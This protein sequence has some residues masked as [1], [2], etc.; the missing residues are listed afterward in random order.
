MYYF[1]R[2]QNVKEQILLAPNLLD[3]ARTAFDESIEPFSFGGTVHLYHMGKLDSGLYVA[4]RTLRTD[5]A[6]GQT[7]L[8]RQMKLMEYY[9]QNAESSDS[10]GE[11]VPNFC[12]GVI[13]GDKAGIFTED[14]TAGNTQEIDSHPDNDYILVGKDKRKV[15]VD[16]D[17][18]SRFIPGLK[19]KYFLG[20]RAI[21][22]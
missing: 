11:L 13:K 16:L 14:L 9:C 18:T 3:I 12:V 6:E 7:N 1:K 20:K 8:E 5:V 10:R 21:R 15:F 22:L 2:S 4:L 19:L 17:G